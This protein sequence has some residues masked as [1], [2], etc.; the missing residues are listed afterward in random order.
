MK[1][2]L[3]TNYANRSYAQKTNRTEAYA[4]PNFTGT[5]QVIMPMGAGLSLKPLKRIAETLNLHVPTSIIEEG[6]D[7]KFGVHYVKASFESTKDAGVVQ[8]LLAEVCKIESEGEKNL[9]WTYTTDQHCLGED[10]LRRINLN[11]Q[12]KTQAEIAEEQ[13][14]LAFVENCI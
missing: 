7:L 5:G 1:V 13:G 12:Y 9:R 8:S 2:Q 4:K 3:Q 6:I 10:A 14:Q 11:P